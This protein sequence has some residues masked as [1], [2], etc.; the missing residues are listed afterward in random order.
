MDN[1]QHPGRWHPLTGAAR[2]RLVRLLWD[3]PGP[4]SAA[5]ATRETWGNA[6]VDD[7]HNPRA[8]VCGMARNYEFVGRLAPNKRPDDLIRLASYY[9]RFVSPDVR[10]ILV[11]K[12]PRRLAYLDA[13]QAL[14][15]EEGFTPWEV[16]FLGHVPHRDLLAVRSL[17]DAVFDTDPQ[18]GAPS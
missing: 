4:Q 11:G 18:H 3:L 8:A 9:R 15:Y 12:A 2:G 13:L 17:V 7:V 6:W 16:M 14:A 10:L 5:W 1:R